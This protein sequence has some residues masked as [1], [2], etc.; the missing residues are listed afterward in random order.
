LAVTTLPCEWFGSHF[1]GACS[2]GA[3]WA[4]IGVGLVVGAICFGLL[5]F[6]AIGKIARQSEFTPGTSRTLMWVWGSAVVFA[7]VA[8]I[9]LPHIGLGELVNTAVSLFALAF[10]LAV[11]LILV[12]RLKLNSFLALLP[13]VPILGTF[14]FLFVVVRAYNATLQ[15]DA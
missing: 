2:Y 13:L 15:S 9:V 1:E 6:R 8:P 3:L 10:L 12:R 5:S 14:V 11:S 7:F 4:S